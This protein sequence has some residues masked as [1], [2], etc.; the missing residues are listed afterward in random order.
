MRKFLII[1]ALCLCAFCLAMAALS[2]ETLEIVGVTDAS[3]V[4]ANMYMDID[5]YLNGEKV[6]CEWT[7]AP[8]GIARISSSKK[9]RL[10]DIEKAMTVEITALHKPTGAQKTVSV[11][12]VPQAKSINILCEGENITGKTV[13]VDMSEGTGALS[14]ESKTNPSGANAAI[15]WTSSDESVA[16]VDENGQVF[17]NT[18]GECVISATTVDGKTSS[19][20]VNGT[21]SAKT[22]EVVA[23]DEMAVGESYTLSYFITPAEAQKDGVTL[24]SSKEKILSVTEDGVITAHRVGK[25]V[26]TVTA[27]SG[28]SKDIEIETYLPVESVQIRNTFVLK[29]G[30]K[31]QL[32]VRVLPKEAK[33][34]TVTFV[35]LNPEIAIVDNDGYVT[36][37]APGTVTILVSAS[38]GVSAHQTMEVRPVKIESFCLTDRFETMKAGDQV[39]LSAEFTP[40]NT[41]ERVIFYSSDN[42]DVAVV[43]ENGLVTAVGAGKCI[44]YARSERSD[45][46]PA[47]FRINVQ[48]EGALPLEGIVV[49][50]NPG[51]QEKSNTKKLPLA[52]GSEKTGNANNSGTAGV[53]TKKREYEV[54]L[55][56]SMRL[57]EML[58]SLG[59]EVVMTRTTNDVNINNIERAQMLNEAG[60]DIALQIH[61]NA[62]EKKNTQ[63]FSV[64]VKYSD[65]ESLA[66]G[67]ILLDTACEISGAK[68]LK[69]NRSNNYMSLNWSETPSL[70]LECGYMTNPEEDV[71]LNTPEYQDALA[72]GI[73]EGL[74]AYFVGEISE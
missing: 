10:L 42:E 57:K 32:S 4:S 35:S 3:A 51:H 16:V 31:E 7:F 1:L 56:I 74:V 19:V 11:L 65:L 71:K 55:E 18:L 29:P 62:S 26:I 39:Q 23:P 14:L 15:R 13:Y 49:G 12:V 28:I 8:S 27:N 34:N 41:T 58:E 66:I 47:L 30:E 36:G 37:V 33:Y 43:D 59:A 52:P 6:E 67:E 61:L 44:I 54:T 9:L 45:I 70:L 20:T 63:G 2:E 25:S 5:A 21:Y 46:D 73:A 38:N 69:V 17:M 40:E 22:L 53:K 68:K 50:L 60:V 72:K 24:K 48:K 64:Y